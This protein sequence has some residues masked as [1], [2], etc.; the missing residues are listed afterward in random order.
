MRSR[1]VPTVLAPALPALVL[2]AIT[3]AGMVDPPQAGLATQ[4]HVSNVT[5]LS[6]SHTVTTAYPVTAR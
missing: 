1:R 4:L 3:T 2:L 5:T 6:T